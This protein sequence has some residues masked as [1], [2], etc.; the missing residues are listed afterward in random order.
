MLIKKKTRNRKYL[1]LNF[2]DE[3]MT[4]KYFEVRREIYEKN[5]LNKINS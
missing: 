3:Y 1:K 5:P 2:G 4:Y